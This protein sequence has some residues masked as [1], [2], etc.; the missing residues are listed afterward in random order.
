MSLFIMSVTFIMNSNDLY[1]LFALQNNN[2]KVI[3]IIKHVK[4][5]GWAGLLNSLSTA[6]ISFINN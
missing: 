1:R 4:T 3:I 5:A 2:S 6:L